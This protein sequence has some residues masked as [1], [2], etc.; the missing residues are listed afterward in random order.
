MTEKE[1]K[2]FGAKATALVPMIVCGSGYT[3]VENKLFQQTDIF[4]AIRN[5]VSKQY[6]TIKI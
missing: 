3:G 1:L 6:C 5:Y 2:I 4:T